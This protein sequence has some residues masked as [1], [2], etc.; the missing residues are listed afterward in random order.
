[1]DHKNLR[2]IL[3]SDFQEPTLAET[4]LKKSILNFFMIRSMLRRIILKKNTDECLLL[5]N[6]IIALNTHGYDKSLRII[7][8]ICSADSVRVFEECL[9]IIAEKRN[10]SYVRC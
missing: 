10:T 3:E 4:E 9:V 2:E 6:I 7:Q 8:I 5:N 1:M